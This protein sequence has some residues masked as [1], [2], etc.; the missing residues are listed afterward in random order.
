MNNIQSLTHP[1]GSDGNSV[2]VSHIKDDWYMFVVSDHYDE[3]HVGLFVHKNDLKE[4]S[5]FLNKVIET[6]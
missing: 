1:I 5:N 2:T 4:L 3:N 6:Q